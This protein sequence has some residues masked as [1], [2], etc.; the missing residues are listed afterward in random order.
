MANQ[1]V[2]QTV[3]NNISNVNTPGY[4]RQTAALQTVEGQFSGDGYIGKGVDVAT[5]NRSYSTFLNRQ[6]TLAGAISAGDTARSDK[7]RQLE[8]L[9]PGGTNALGAAVGDMLNAFSDVATAP[10]DIT[11]RTV[12]LTKV[13][14]TAKRINS[15]SQNLDELQAAVKLELTQKIT[16]INTVAS[17]IAK[18]NEKI[19][20][21]QG[22]GQPPNDLLDQRDQLIRDLNKYVQTSSIAAD[23]GSIG[24]FVGASPLVLNSTAAT[25]ALVKDDY[26][27][28]L[29]N[30]IAFV[31]HGASTT[32]DENMLGGGEIPGL[33]RF[34]NTDLAEARNLLGRYTFAV[35][36]S[37]NVQHKL[38]LD[39]SGTPGSNL[40]VLAQVSDPGN[41]LPPA[42]PAILNTG[43][44]SL[45]LAV[46]DMSKFAAS[47]YEVV[48]SN[49]TSGSITRKSD[50]LIVTF[51]QTPPT[52]A[53]ILATL[54][55]LDISLT[56]GAANLGDRF[57]L[58]PFSHSAST[59]RAEF[60]APRQLAVASPIVGKMGTTNT[61]S[62]QQISLTAKMNP[63]VSTTTTPVVLKF[64]DASNYSVNGVGPV[65]YT[66][67]QVINSDPDPLLNEWSLVLQGVPKAGDTFTVLDIKNT[68]T[69]PLTNRPY[70]NN[71]NL[72]LN[73]GNAS[74]MTGLRDAALFDG[75]ALTDGYAGLIAQLGVRTQSA[76]YT[77]EV[78]AG[79]AATLE[80]DRTGVAG[81]NLDEEA[82][83]LL[84]YQQA[85]QASAKVIQIAQG[86]FDT[87]IQTISR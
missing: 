80:T 40:F 76:A 65:A 49:A 4:S 62:L 67:G 2:L 50:G 41:I 10:T 59:I 31:S 87:L 29:K 64:I 23:D 57:L 61:G 78:S 68:S 32:L 53:P 46:N 18:V 56:A 5:I 81:V 6:S 54:D 71:V 84:Q 24:L 17:N 74:A 83:K 3:G 37:M 7:L 38:G 26:G 14:E 11:A 9:F 28:P 1:T 60:A 27:D 66:S 30:K 15:T 55:G 22:N 16:V 20:R 47:D 36:E 82:A 25:L 79:L 43:S 69:D 19:A 21:A 86:I 77:A 58:K 85:Y 48:F 8:N 42:S 44:A 13:D 73:S 75:A 63:P 72:A 39:L 12:A 52:T 33:L 35:G 70:N 45:A 34:Q 51:P